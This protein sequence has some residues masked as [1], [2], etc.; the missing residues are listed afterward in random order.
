MQFRK[1]CRLWWLT[2]PVLALDRITKHA[3]AAAL[4]PDGVR[5]ALPSLLSWAYSENRGAAFSMLYGR[6]LFLILLTLAL[7]VGL[8]VYLLRKGDIPTPERCGLWMIFAG[9]LGNLWDRICL[10]YVIDFIRLDF[11]HFAIFN[12]ADIFVCCGAALVVLSVL[13][14]EPRRKAH[15]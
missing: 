15:G 10:G 7:A 12:V 8:L 3:A 11:V 9:G 14:Y 13:I 6:S 1:G 2:L 5:T 4:A